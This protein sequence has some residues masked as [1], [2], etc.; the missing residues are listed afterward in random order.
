MRKISRIAAIMFIA[1]IVQSCDGY[2]YQGK[3]ADEVV[4]QAAEMPLL[5]AYEFYVDVYTNT[6]PPMID[7]SRM[8]TKY[9]NDA[10]VLLRTKALSTRDKRELEGDLAALA[11]L[12]YKCEHGESDYFLRKAVDVGAAKIYVSN[13]CNR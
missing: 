8:F 4:Q 5:E 2:K 1:L 7:A 6:H 10:I 11:L 9:G 12:G 13:L 3:T